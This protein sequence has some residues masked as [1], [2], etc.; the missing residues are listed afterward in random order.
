MINVKRID[1][2]QG[3][4]PWLGKAGLDVQTQFV[5]VWL[6]GTC[7]WT[8]TLMVVM[9]MMMTITM[10]ATML[11]LVMIMTTSGYLA[12]VTGQPPLP[13][14]DSHIG[15]RMAQK[16]SRLSAQCPIVQGQVYRKLIS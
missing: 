6:P 11:L 8:A 3:G 16:S 9:M 2:L 7:H 12:L 15:A 4:A 5:S 1:F 13:A 10:M 14:Y